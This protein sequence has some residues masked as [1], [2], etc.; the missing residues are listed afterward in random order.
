MRDVW[1]RLPGENTSLLLTSAQH[2]FEGCVAACDALGEHGNASL[3][4]IDSAVKANF[5]AK[6]LLRPSNLHRAWFGLFQHPVKLGSRT[7]WQPT[8]EVRQ[9]AHAQGQLNL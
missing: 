3:A 6:H 4:C 9:R 1:L 2:S 7:E 5:V 8:V